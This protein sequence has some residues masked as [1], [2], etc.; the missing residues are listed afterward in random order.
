MSDILK[1]KILVVEDTPDDMDLI[2]SVMRGKRIGGAIDVVN[3]EDGNHAL[4]LLEEMEGRL[5]ALL[6]DFNLGARSPSGLVLAQRAIHISVPIVVVNTDIL[7]EQRTQ[8]RNT[9]QAYV[10]DRPVHMEVR[11]KMG[12]DELHSFVQFVSQVTREMS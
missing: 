6:T 10:A 8:L 7:E 4:T 1:P 12:F 11:K 3:T 9:L 2:V 5:S